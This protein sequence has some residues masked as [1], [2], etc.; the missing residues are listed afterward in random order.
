MSFTKEDELKDAQVSELRDVFF[1]FDTERTGTVAFEHVDEI[2][3]T[4]GRVVTDPEFKKRVKSTVPADLEKKVKFPEFVDLVHKYTRAFNAQKDLH[5][6]FRVFDRDG[7]GFI[8]TAELRH[9]VT[10]LGE[11]MTEEEADELIR[12]A[13]ANNEGHVDYEE[14]I[15]T[16]STPLPPDQYGKPPK[17]RPPPPPTTSTEIQPAGPDALVTPSAKGA[18]AERA[19]TSAV[20]DAPAGGEVAA[21]AA[22]EVSDKSGEKSA[23]KSGEKS[24]H[25][26]EHRSEDKSGQGSRKSSTKGSATSSGKGSTSASGKG[27]A[28]GSAETSKK[29]SRRSSGVGESHTAVVAANSGLPVEAVMHKAPAVKDDGKVADK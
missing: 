19:S 18:P 21:A 3:R 16:I 5:D 7:H 14:F 15:K 23:D 9:V 10:T 27:S 1:K 11:R 12:E 8:T 22:S 28:A 29:S 17:K 6:A 25:S 20:S 26:S 2:L 13:D 4:A 24:G